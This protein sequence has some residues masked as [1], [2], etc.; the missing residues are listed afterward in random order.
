MQMML[1]R[2][3]A[4]P[5]QGRVEMDDAYWGGE[6]RGGKRGRGAEDKQPFVA[7]V[8]TTE[9]EKPLKMKLSVVKGFQSQEIGQWGQ[10]HLLPGS[11]VVIKIVFS[12]EQ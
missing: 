2:D 12:T 1:E 9:D 6:R 7:A 10:H 8:Q 4:K 3:N 5:L 11:S